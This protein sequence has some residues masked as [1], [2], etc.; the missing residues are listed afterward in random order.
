MKNIL[1]VPSRY[2]SVSRRLACTPSVRVTGPTS[3]LLTGLIKG[4]SP[5]ITKETLIGNLLAYCMCDLVSVSY[6][7]YC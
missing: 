6:I 7:A 3:V 4:G 2:R 5:S 1:S